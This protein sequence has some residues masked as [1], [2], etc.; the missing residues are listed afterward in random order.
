MSRLI[1]ISADESVGCPHCSRTFALSEGISRQAVDRYANA[2]GRGS[3]DGFR[4]S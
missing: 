4:E 2:Y 1:V 3:Y